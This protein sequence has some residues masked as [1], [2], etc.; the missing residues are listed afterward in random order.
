VQTL[1]PI[2]FAVGNRDGLVEDF[3]LPAPLELLGSRVPAI[4]DTVP[5][6]PVDRAVRD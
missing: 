3:R 6:E 2:I 1:L 5:I 4:Y